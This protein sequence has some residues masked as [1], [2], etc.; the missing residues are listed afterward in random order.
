LILAAASGP[1]SPPARAAVPESLAEI[2][3]RGPG[4]PGSAGAELAVEGAGPL[5]FATPAGG[6]AEL[7]L[8]LA[9]VPGPAGLE[10][11]GNAAL[12]SL[13]GVPGEIR[14]GELA[15]LY[16]LAA[17]LETTP[18]PVPEPG[19]V[20]LLA[21]GLGAL[22]RMARRRASCHPAGRWSGPPH[23]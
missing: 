10:L 12:A 23:G 8:Y 1:L 14:L 3:G 15:G 22:A 5:R 7:V 16:G 18:Q 6:A 13:L 9:A 2:E 20:T 4:A 11:R 19:G 21:L 17:P